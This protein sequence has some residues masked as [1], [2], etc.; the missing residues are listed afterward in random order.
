M[1]RISSEDLAA[2]RSKYEAM[3][4]LRELHE[5]AKE[6]RAFVEPD[7]K[8]KLAALADAFPGALREIDE[9]PFATITSRIEEIERAEQNAD[10]IASWMIVQLT[11][12]RFARG[13]LAI[14]RWLGRSRVALPSRDELV[15]AIEAGVVMHVDEALLWIDAVDRIARPEQGRVMG[16]VWRRVIDELSLECSIEEARALAFGVNVEGI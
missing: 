14:K 7:P 1:P 16:V 9:L 8:A 2:L 12:H 10:A 5:R 15:R 13:A 4:S 3:R 11:F 6:D